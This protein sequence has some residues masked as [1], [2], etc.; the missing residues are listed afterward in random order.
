MHSNYKAKLNI[1]IL[2]FGVNLFIKCRDSPPSI[3]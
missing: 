3:T 2:D 1:L